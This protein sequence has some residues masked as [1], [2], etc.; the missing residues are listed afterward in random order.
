MTWMLFIGTRLAW[1]RDWR[2]EESQLPR[3]L[4]NGLEQARVGLCKATYSSE[5]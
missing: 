5:K 3:D 4:W 2:M 1:A